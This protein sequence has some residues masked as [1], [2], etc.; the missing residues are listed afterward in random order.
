[1]AE[2]R[3]RRATPDDREAILDLLAATFGTGGLVDDPAFWAWKHE[4]SPWGPSPCLVAEAE[5]VLVAL[6]AFLPWRF[7][8]GEEE[9]RAVRAVDTVT[10]P[11]WQ[12]RGLFRRLTLELAEELRQEGIAFVFN[13]PNR[14]S[15]PGYLRMG[16][17]EVAR[18]PVWVKLLRPL[19]VAGALLRPGPTA[20]EGAPVAVGGAIESFLSLPGLG[21]WLGAATAR[22]TRYHTDRT[23]SY[24][25]WRYARTP[26]IAYR[27]RW[28]LRGGDG[29]P[30]GAATVFR[31]KLRRGLRE[32]MLAE[33]LV[34]PGEA[35]TAADLLRGLLDEARPDVATAIAARGT[36]EASALRGA[37]FR[38][39]RAAGPRLVVRGLAAP[40]APEA[41][42]EW[43]LGLGDLELF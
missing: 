17:R 18:V 38:E 42:R 11:G 15:R 33:V 35:A 14:R 25:D 31:Q 39:L 40:R 8:R 22:E 36:P 9:V 43:R 34:S 26:R 2:P 19:R 20:D 27:V 24:L 16:W 30:R 41:W 7:R 29:P 12:G 5:G 28:N 10:R 32:L 13:T 1:M 37:G 23:A 21:P 3:I 4:S 6:R